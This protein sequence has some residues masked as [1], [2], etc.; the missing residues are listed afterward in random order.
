MMNDPEQLKDL[1]KLPAEERLRLGKW[2]IDSAIRGV[3]SVNDSRSPESN[4][5]L[6]LVGR[7]EGGPGNT[8]ERAE[9]ILEC[10]VDKTHGLTT[11]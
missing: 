10:E 1:L 8:A 11:R 9:E 3:E 4:G 7:Y 2:L 5:L 6:A